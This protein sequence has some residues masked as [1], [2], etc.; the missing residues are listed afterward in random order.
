MVRDVTSHA[1]EPEPGGLLGAEDAPR[2]VV[3][4]TNT[5][6]RFDTDSPA[7]SK[8]M[9]AQPDT[10]EMKTVRGGTEVPAA[11]PVNASAEPM[12]QDLGT[13]D[14]SIPEEGRQAP[15]TPAREAAA[16]GV[17]PPVESPYRPAGEAGDARAGETGAQWVV[18][19]SGKWRAFGWD[20][21]GPGLEELLLL[22]VTADG[23]VSGVVDDGDGVM[24]GD[25]GDC[26]IENG[27]VDAATRCMTFDQVYAD[28]A[29]TRW[30]ATYDVEEDQLKAGIW[31][32]E[33]IGGFE[34]NRDTGEHTYSLH[35]YRACSPSVLVY[36]APNATLAPTGQLGLGVTA[37]S[38]MTHF[39]ESTGT[40][41][42][43]LLVKQ[44]PQA[45]IQKVWA[46]ERDATGEVKLCR[47]PQVD[48]TGIDAIVSAPGPTAEDLMEQLLSERET[49][50]LELEQMRT[51][52]RDEVEAHQKHL[53]SESAAHDSAVRE[54]TQQKDAELAARHEE[55]EAALQRITETL[56]EQLRA[57][58]ETCALTQK[59]LVAMTRTKD[60]LSWA[61]TR[62]DALCAGLRA[63]LAA[64]NSEVQ[65][66]NLD[67]T[68][69]PLLAQA[70]FER[71]DTDNDGVVDAADI[72]AWHKAEL[73]L[74]ND[75]PKSTESILAL[76]EEYGWEFDDS[77]VKSPSGAPAVGP[78]AFAQIRKHLIADVDRAR[79]T[80]AAQLL[81]QQRDK[82][83]LHA[84]QAAFRRADG[85]GDGAVDAADIAKWYAAEVALPGDP[86]K[87]ADE[88]EEMIAEIGW[89]F[90]DEEV[91]SPRGNKAAG[92]QAFIELRRQLIAEIDP[93]A[94]ALEKS[95]REQRKERG[96][97]V[98]HA[99]LV[100]ALE[101]MAAIEQANVPTTPTN[102]FFLLSTHHVVLEFCTVLTAAQAITRRSRWPRTPRSPHCAKTWIGRSARRMRSARTRSPQ[103]SSSWT[104]RSTR[105]AG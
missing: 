77:E 33:C 101:E 56:T 87:L 42:V 89:E 58:S 62:S 96:I 78:S 44:D 67:T 23:T 51:C 3:K 81:Q 66:E 40:Q 83:E 64:V 76:I 105:P 18:Q 24:C 65:A 11:P 103:C 69:D 85:D 35:G 52:H 104:K 80:A 41:W 102:D 88:L 53:R 19:L 39:D 99:V 2:T 38:S 49:H 21:A 25:D 36:A 12:S 30:E 98:E 59:R 61:L 47:A 63:Q 27:R 97:V 68:D 93:R 28:G 31:A 26:K 10:I 57:E 74:P 34:A 75:T 8:E 13:A 45:K 94:S 71:A 14:A 1:P 22:D 73:A 17:S 7:T 15:Q 32:G 5:K 37:A 72:V 84:A 4:A 70:A 79:A 95:L 20:E 60:E 86:P 46:I 50:E 92:V 90:D 100:D 6:A 82:H 48:G 54:L 55:H 29:V 16:A 91:Q 43:Q 9:S